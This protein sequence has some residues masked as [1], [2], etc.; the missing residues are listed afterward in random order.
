MRAADAPRR[1]IASLPTRQVVVGAGALHDGAATAK[2]V[3]HLSSIAATVEAPSRPACPA[4]SYAAEMRVDSLTHV[5]SSPST[6]VGG[7]ELAR[8]R[9]HAAEKRVDALT[10]VQSSPNTAIGGHELAIVL[11]RRRRISEGSCAAQHI[12][13]MPAPTCQTVQSARCQQG[14][15]AVEPCGFRPGLTSIQGSTK[16]VVADGPWPLCNQPASILACRAKS[17][18][19]AADALRPSLIVS[20]VA[21]DSGAETP[22]TTAG[23]A[24]ACSSYLPMV[25]T[26]VAPLTLS[27]DAS[28]AN[29]Q[30]PKAVIQPSV[31]Q[32]GDVAPSKSC[33]PTEGALTPP[34]GEQLAPAWV[35][36]LAAVD[37]KH[38]EK[39]LEFN[40]RVEQGM[41]KPLRPPFSVQDASS[42]A[43][44]WDAMQADLDQTWV[45]SHEELSLMG[46]RLQ[47]H[48][49]AAGE[50]NQA[51]DA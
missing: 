24:P 47:R 38:L 13:A 33:W 35:T 5:Q 37:L 19:Y 18:G 50:T 21:S 41:A 27:E 32:I 31:A 44:K 12:S 26:M 20:S 30:G 17:S 9:S 1:S 51:L 39:T 42:R 7:H 14:E 49:L 11:E 45:E 40:E 28:A 6:S 46:H 3:G 34:S 36:G 4:R 10:H 22:I 2:L 15:C 29:T 48:A 43:E 16:T 25:D 23:G 8:A